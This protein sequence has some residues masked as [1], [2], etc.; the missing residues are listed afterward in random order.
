MPYQLG[1]VVVVCGGWLVGGVWLCS[2]CTSGLLLVVLLVLLCV[3]LSFDGMGWVWVVLLGCIA[4]MWLFVCFFP[5][6]LVYLCG[7]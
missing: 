7:Y 5:L 2:L 4:W 1:D 3:G 6:L